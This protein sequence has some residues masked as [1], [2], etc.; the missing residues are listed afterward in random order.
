MPRKARKD[1]KTEYLHV[2]SQGIN[3]E[4]IFRTD[5]LK[6]KYK[7]LLKKYIEES[8]AKILSY[9]IMGNHAHV[10]FHTIEP[11]EVTKVM[12]MVNTNFAMHYNYINKRVGVVFRNRYFTQPILSKEQLTKKKFEYFCKKIIRNFEHKQTKDYKN[13]KKDGIITS[14]LCNGCPHW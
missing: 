5:E 9:C 13:F 12:Q 7:N 3:K 11:Y 2:M 1:M 4:F 6:K 8:N 10:L 14:Y